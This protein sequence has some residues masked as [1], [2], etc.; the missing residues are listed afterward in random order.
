MIK[1]PWVDNKQF[2]NDEVNKLLQIPLSLNQLTNYG[3]LVRELE[4][5]FTEKLELDNDKTVIVVNNGALGMNALAS[6]INMFYK[7]KL[8]YATQAF[9][10]PCSA[11]GILSDSIIVDIDDEL[12]LDLTTLSSDNEDIDGIIVTNLFGNVC[13]I[14]KYCEWADKN[15]KILLFDNA[16]VPFTSYN[17]KNAN[18]YGHGSIISLHHTKPI[19]FGEG[20]LIV[21]DKK[22]EKYVRK[23]INFGFSVKNGVVGWDRL[24]MNCK[25]SEISAA[26]ILSY[27]QNNKEILIKHYNK[28]YEVFVDKIKNIKGVRI[29]PNFGDVPFIS[30]FTV[31]FDDIEITNDHINQFEL[32][33][34]TA[35]KY[36]TPLENLPNSTKLFKHILCLPCHLSVSEDT[37]NRYILIIKDILE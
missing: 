16:T 3:P 20:G 11:Q 29:F 9:T 33:N 32:N 18:N 2:D 22:Y 4:L 21:V 37:L 12:S 15:D 14:N 7:R 6:G 10:F 28:I 8:K 31:I 17:N 13:N 5:Y 34:I 24:G 23:C 35:K 26:Y 25:M 27:I 1:I 36:Y 30:S 19:G